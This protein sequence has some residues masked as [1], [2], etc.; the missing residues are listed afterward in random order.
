M[1]TTT[2]APSIFVFDAAPDHLMPM[3]ADY[4]REC[5]IAGAGSVEVELP[6]HSVVVISATRYL[7]ADADVAAVVVNDVLQVLCTRTGR[8]AVIMREFTDWT[9]YTVRRSTR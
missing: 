3:S 5:Q 8:D 7:P 6:D 4:Y 1:D 2:T 9:A